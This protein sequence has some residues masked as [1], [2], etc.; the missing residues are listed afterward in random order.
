MDIFENFEN[1]I[2]QK[3]NVKNEIPKIKIRQMALL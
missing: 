2:Y 3:K 1:T